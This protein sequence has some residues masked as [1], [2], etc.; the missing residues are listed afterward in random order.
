MSWLSSI[1]DSISSWYKSHNS[2]GDILKCNK[3][4]F[5]DLV[6]DFVNKTWDEKDKLESDSKQYVSDFMS[7]VTAK[8]PDVLKYV[9]NYTIT[10]K[11]DSV[12]KAAFTL[13]PTK[14]EAINY[15]Y[16]QALKLK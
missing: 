12:I 13:K 5:R 16:E 7:C 2:F 15:I 8:F 1:L 6:E 11:M 4:V 9:V 14:Q 3:I 10:E